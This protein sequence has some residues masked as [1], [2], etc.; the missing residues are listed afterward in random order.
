LNGVDRLRI[1]NV[2][3]LT[4]ALLSGNWLRSDPVALNSGQL[5]LGDF[6]DGWNKLWKERVLASRANRFRVVQDGKEK[7]LML[8]SDR[9]ASGF[10]RELKI[11][12]PSSGKINWRWKIKHGLT[13]NHKEREK[14]SDD[15]AARV[16]VVFEPHFLN[17]K[18]R[19]VC[20][21]WA[22]NERVGSIYPSP[23]TNS[24]ATI[25][26]ESGD[27]LAG[28]WVQEEREFVADYKKYFGKDP[29]R[30]SAVAVMMDTDNTGARTTA[31]FD[32]LKI[33]LPAK[34]IS[35]TGQQ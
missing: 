31:Y 3:I 24:V 8:E 5:L 22:G 18:T 28:Q 13:E 20:Y 9:S 27:K 21:V 12:N 4:A 32:G 7:V 30:V 33:F 19:S 10:W 16:F 17:W 15:Y 23:Y 29:K 35:Q 11:A 2:L 34:P 26:L 25:V 14:S 1:R 6:S